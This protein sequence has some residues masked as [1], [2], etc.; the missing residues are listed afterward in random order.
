M[1]TR[2]FQPDSLSPAELDDYLARGWYRMGSALIGTEYLEKEGELCS[3]IWTRLDLSRHR[4]RSS[5]RKRMAR[6]ARRY[7]LETGPLVL[8]AE[9][10]ELY[11]RY[12][13]ML[14]GKRVESLDDVLGGEVGRRLFDTREIRLRAEGR[15]AAFSW[16]DVGQDSVE[17]L[18]GVYD[19]DHRRHGLGFHTMLLE[20]EHAAAMGLRY[21]YSGYILSEPSAMDYKVRVGDLEYLDPTSGQWL[22]ASPYPPGE[23]PADVLRRRLDEAGEALSRAG[24]RVTR[25]LNSALQIPEL[26]D[27][28]PACSTEPIL[29]YCDVPGFAWGVLTTW[30][31]EHGRYSLFGGRPV[32]VEIEGHTGP[33]PAPMI[34]LFLIGEHLS[35][36]ASAEEVAFWVRYHLGSI[37]SP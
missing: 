25:V 28:I 2:R 8:D 11:A 36:H 1:I 21:H 10:D 17:S 20:I 29:L 7:Q 15:L 13:E 6:N 23:S 27:H 3:T 35:D 26:K 16:F 19:P 22:P 24:A 34:H 32:A 33:P 9:H 37:G 4:F 18:I 14:G 12:R 30:D 31:E 5:V